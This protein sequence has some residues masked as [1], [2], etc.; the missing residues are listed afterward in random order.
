MKHDHE[1]EPRGAVFSPCQTW[2]YELSNTWDR[3]DLTLGFIGCNPSK[4]SATA[5]DPTARKFDGFTRR[6]GFGGWYAANLFALVSTNPKGLSTFE[7]D[8]VGPETDERLRATANRCDMVIVC[9]GRPGGVYTAR[10]E[11]VVGMLEHLS[12]WCFGK[13]K[14][15]HP[16][17]PSRIAYS[18]P[19]VPYD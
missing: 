8:P 6:L 16:R 4:A 10:V 2:R 13:T 7:G 14:D 19:L 11:H 17:H 18:T 12:L 5:W 1:Q 15:G 3:A 9:W